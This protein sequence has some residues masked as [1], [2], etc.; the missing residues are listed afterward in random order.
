MISCPDLLIYIYVNFGKLNKLMEILNMN[1]YFERLVYE[2]I[3]LA[4][5]NDEQ[6]YDEHAQ[7]DAVWVFSQL[8]HLLEVD[9]QTDV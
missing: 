6:V 5:L 2:R 7:I 8:S 3:C 1:S 9:Q 4:H